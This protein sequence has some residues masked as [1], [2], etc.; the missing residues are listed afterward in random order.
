M[1]VIVEFCDAVNAQS[2]VSLL[3]K[4]EARHQKAHMIYVC[5]GSAR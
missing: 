2:A 1:N 5:C 4:L 3:R